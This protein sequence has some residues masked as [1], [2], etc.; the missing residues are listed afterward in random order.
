MPTSKSS[1]STQ[2]LLLLEAYHSS[3][4][5][6]VQADLKAQIIKLNINLIDQALGKVNTEEF[7]GHDDFRQAGL[8]GLVMAIEQFDPSLTKTFKSFALL[9]IQQQ[10]QDYATTIVSQALGEIPTAEP[11]PKPIADDTPSGIL[12]VETLK[13]FQIYRDHPTPTLRDRLVKLNMGLVKKE[14]HHW[15]NQCTETYDDLLQVGCLGLLRAIDRFDMDKGYAFSTFAVPYIRGE[16]QHYLRDKSPT[17]KIPRQWL[18]VYNQ[19]CRVLRHLRTQ[20]K[21]DPS[22]AEVAAAIGIKLSEWQ[23]IKLA[24]R[25]RSPLSLDAPVSDEDEGCVSLGELVQDH[26][27]RSFQLAQEDSMRL[28]QALTHLE[29]RT[30]E[31][32]EFVFLREFTHREVAEILGIS[33]VTVSRQ[34]KK[35][36]TILKEIMT[37]PLD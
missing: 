4:S 36:I 33:A 13:V 30:R 22:D 2:T 17:L 1:R 35:G 5:I 6:E 11:S 8:Q 16:I 21:R 10:I 7:L 24:C 15:T 37:T 28:H 19:G 3:Q 12:K 29:D 25:N 26:N 32:V 20:L 18:E 14:A 31:V 23:E 27:Y 34:L 9:Q